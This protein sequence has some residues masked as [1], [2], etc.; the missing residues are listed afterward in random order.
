MTTWDFFTHGRA[1]VLGTDKTPFN[2][3]AEGSELFRT[4]RVPNATII[5]NS[6]I[7][8]IVAQA[9][10]LDGTDMRITAAT[11]SAQ[12]GPEASAALLGQLLTT[13]KLMKVPLLKD[14]DH[15]NIVDM[16][17][18][19][20]DRCLGS[21][22]VRQTLSCNMTHHLVQCTAVKASAQSVQWTVKRLG[23]T[24]AKQWLR[25]DIVLKNAAGQPCKACSDYSA[26]TAEDE[27]QLKARPGVWEAYR[28]VSSIQS[29]LKVVQI[30]GSN[31]IISAAVQQEF[32]GCP[33]SV[34]AEMDDLQKLFTE[35]YG[36]CLKGKLP[37]T[38]GLPSTTPEDPRAGISVGPPIAPT[39]M[40]STETE[41]GVRK[42]YK[43]TVECKAFDCKGV[44]ILGD[45]LGN[46]YLVS[47]DCQ[48]AELFLAMKT[49]FWLPLACRRLQFFLVGHALEASGL[50]RLSS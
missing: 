45:D 31:A 32:A 25:G 17:A 46:V 5:S 29:K 18:H 2:V 37:S 26:I 24:L 39:E 41:E 1:C 8:P 14:T 22:S 36:D 7:V 21:L 30:H 15:L 23:T 3:F 34:R 50:A 33:A 47:K 42:A 48:C 4:G 9:D 43:I 38:T 49:C 19:S 44:M 13:S 27:E 11:R 20:G 16:N 35:N 28:G 12:R 10:E 40:K 6:D